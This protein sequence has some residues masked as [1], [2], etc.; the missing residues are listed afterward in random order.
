MS[1]VVASTSEAFDGHAFGV[2]ARAW[3]FAHARRHSRHVRL[4]RIA[5]PALV[6]LGFA[7]IFGVT[8]FRPLDALSG[9]SIDPGNV[10]VSGTKITM[11]APRVSGF[12]RDSRPYE[13][14]AAAAA[15]DIT[16]P[17]VL[18]LKNIQA[19]MTLPNDGAVEMRAASGVYATKD[20]LMNIR[21]D[22]L[23][24]STTG[25]E[26]RLSEAQVEM[27]K[28]RIVSEKPVAVKMFNGTLNSN[29]LEVTDSGALARFDGGVVANFM[30]NSGPEAKR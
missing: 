25:Y 22:V 15:Q 20:D 29:R 14:T 27:K 18:E 7:V 1:S 30:L 23:L 9:L 12:T 4:M 6:V 3:S 5:V 11:Q 10:V 2:R 28:G 21:D 26:G 24:T 16:K 8:F 17:D 19:H 13:F